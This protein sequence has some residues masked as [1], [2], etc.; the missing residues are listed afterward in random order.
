MEA[1]FQRLLQALKQATQASDQNCREV[2]GRL[3]Q[4]AIRICTE[5][6]RIQASGEI[7]TWALHL[8][9]HRLTQCLRYYRLGSKRGKL[10]L[11][12]TLSA[13]V[14]RYITPPQ[15][16]SSYQVRLLLIED[17]LQNF[18]AE[19][20]NALR[21]ECSVTA[22]YQP[23]TALELA[24][25]MAFAERYGKR[26]IPLPGRRGQQLIILR[27]QTFSKQQPPETAVDIEQAAAAGSSENAE[28]RWP[29]LMKR[30]REQIGSQLEE[31]EDTLRYRVVEELI[32][33]FN[34]KDQTAC[35]S[36]FA[37]RLM[38]L[39]THEI[40]AILGLTSR[41]RDY[42]QQRF[43]YHLLKF[44]FSYRWELVHEWLGADLDNSLGL[45][46][47]QW[48]DLQE[49]LTLKQ[50]KLLQLKHQGESNTAI[51][52]ALDLSPTQ[53]KKQ[54]SNLLER[55]WEIRNL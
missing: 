18:Y 11:N 25:Y 41:E 13:I 17:F 10:E 46:T 37:L 55:A 4:E 15:V 31:T 35:A 44:A 27:A 26:R 7:D 51:L 45:T 36:Y 38:D 50:S 32:E 29:A 9:Q 23:H 30:L 19:S 1:L 49:K 21:R 43:K 14:Y 12:S 40:E 24:E 47:Q 20:M 5:S 16:Q 39:P 6:Q 54:W 34:E 52:A 8:G 33:Y 2:A 3:S 22:N 53:L 28:Q 48:N 42:L